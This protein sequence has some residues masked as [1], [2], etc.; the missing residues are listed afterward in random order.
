MLKISELVHCA[1]TTITSHLFIRFER[2][3][4]EWKVKE[5]KY[6]SDIGSF[7]RSY[8]VWSQKFQI[9]ILLKSDQPRISAIW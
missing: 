8:L 2:I 3:S 4:N 9:L 7:L 1:P 5:V 6:M